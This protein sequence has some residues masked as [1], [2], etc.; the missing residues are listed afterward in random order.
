VDC[1]GKD[2]G[3][4]VTVGCIET[5]GF[6]GARRNDIAGIDVANGGTVVGLLVDAGGDVIRIRRG[7]RLQR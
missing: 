5:G 7:H 3:F 1:V 4:V 6:C 2:I